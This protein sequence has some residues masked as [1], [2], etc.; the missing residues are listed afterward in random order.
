MV[1]RCKGIGVSHPRVFGCNSSDTSRL[2]SLTSN[3]AGT[4]LPKHSTL[5]TGSSVAFPRAM[6]NAMAAGHPTV[7]PSV[8]ADLPSSTA[9]PI[10]N[11]DRT[12]VVPIEP[13]EGPK[14]RTKLRLYSILAS[15][16]VS[17]S[18]HAVQSVRG[19]P[20]PTQPLAS[21]LCSWPPSTPPSSP[22]PYQ[23]SAPICTL[24]PAMSG[25]AAHT[26]W[27]PPPPA[28]SG[29]NA[30]TYGAARSCSSSRRVCSPPP[31]SSRR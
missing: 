10:A 2:K 8:P 24:P 1:R 30:A 7:H 15:V 29:R 21:S 26:S 11:A 28:P 14:N 18:I 5:P 25:S 22:S 20:R 3:I 9:A 16:Y 27:P 23:Q 19:S 4:F 17:H 12:P 13:E 31:A 6:G